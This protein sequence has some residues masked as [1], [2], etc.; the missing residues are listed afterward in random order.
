MHQNKTKQGTLLRENTK[1]SPLAKFKNMS[2]Q[3]QYIA[4]I[5]MQ[6]PKSF[7]SKDSKENNLHWN[8]INIKVRNRTKLENTKYEQIH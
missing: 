7:V 3:M 6:T 5:V 8:A 2:Y 1:N 4:S